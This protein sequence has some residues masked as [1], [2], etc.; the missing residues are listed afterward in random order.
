LREVD[1][2]VLSTSE[3]QLYNNAVVKDKGLK[4]LLHYWGGRMKQKYFLLIATFSMLLMSCTYNIEPDE[5]LRIVKR[6][7][8]DYKER[9]S[10]SI[11]NYYKNPAVEKFKYGGGYVGIDLQQYTKVVINLIAQAVANQDISVKQSANKVI[12]IRVHD[13]KYQLGANRASLEITAVLGNGV[14]VN[15]RHQHKDHLILQKSGFFDAITDF[16]NRAII[17][18][19]E[20]L[21]N[22]PDFVKFMN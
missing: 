12:K 2:S 15:I 3:V 4:S 21:L 18:A 10:I 6:A 11:K 1:E 17:G 22:H 9:Q 19:T 14:L 20:K 16:Y 5:N 7:V 13:F 8:P